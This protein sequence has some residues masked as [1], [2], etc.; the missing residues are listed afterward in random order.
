MLE[1]VPET[2]CWCRIEPQGVIAWWNVDRGIF[3]WSGEPGHGFEDPIKP[4]PESW[5]IYQG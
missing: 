4:Q 3:E 5:S 1:R 2:S